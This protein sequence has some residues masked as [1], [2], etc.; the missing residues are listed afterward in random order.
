MKRFF[1]LGVAGIFAFSLGLVPAVNSALAA[2]SDEAKPTIDTS[3]KATLTIHKYVKDSF[4]TEAGTGEKLTDTANL[5]TPIDGVKFK[6]QKVKLTNDFATP[7]GLEEA[8]GLTAETAKNKID[9]S[10]TE[11]TLTTAGGGKV[12]KSDLGLGVY[13]VTEVVDPTL[14]HEGK[15]LV[16]A[17]PFLVML[18]MT[19]PAGNDW[20]YDVH[21]Y[22]KNQT[23]GSK[24]TVTDDT[25]QAGQ[26]ISFDISADVPPVASG[27]KL[28]KIVIEDTLDPAKL[29]ALAE[30]GVTKVAVS[31]DPETVLD[32]PADYTVGYEAS[33][34]KY[35]ITLTTA[36]L[37]K[38]Q[39]KTKGANGF[40]I[41]AT[42]Q[43]TVKKVDTGDGKIKNKATV[44]TNNGSG[45][46][47]VTTETNETETIYGKLKIHK[48]ADGDSGETNLA[49]AVFELYYCD[50]AGTNISGSKLTVNGDSSWTTG[51]DGT[52]TI[53][54]LHV[55]DRINDAAVS[56]KKKYCL[57]ETQAPTGYELLPAPVAVEFASTD[58]GTSGTDLALKT[59]KIKNVPSS[60]PWLPMTGGPGII[61]LVIAGVSIIAG[62]TL[63]GLRSRKLKK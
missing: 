28:A 5:G 10:F 55:T 61:I 42:I 15:A 48:Y 20:N 38:V 7:A 34:Q 54:G 58:L 36:G 2:P 18:P 24:K 1:R 56:D 37:E 13:L 47:D 32:N 25:I 44:I 14:K 23:T 62:G 3:K 46:G 57:L 63:Y 22:P 39:A 16:P 45:G 8:R 60:S 4:G 12:A 43:A 29:T 11:E 6:L 51:P 21:V 33:T 53:D 31:G 27:S 50:A 17:K 35:T 52:V 49:G 30:A 9:S 19:R 40:Q 59:A 41:I 26:K